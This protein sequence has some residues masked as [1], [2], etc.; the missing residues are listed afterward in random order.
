M[1]IGHGASSGR[2]PWPLVFS[3]GR[4]LQEPALAIWAGL[5]ANVGAAQRALIHRAS[6]NGAALRGS[7]SP[8]MER[9]PALQ[10]AS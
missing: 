8:S 3:F 6:C 10:M 1:N 5:E 7:Y 2:S 9:E 4:A